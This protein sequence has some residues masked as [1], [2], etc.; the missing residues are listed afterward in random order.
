MKE[1]VARCCKFRALIIKATNDLPID[2]T[3][4]FQFVVA[5]FSVS[6][7]IIYTIVHQTCT[8]YNIAYIL[9]VCGMGGITSG[10]KFIVKYV[11]FVTQ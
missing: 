6:I 1:S 8:P 5:E 10:W 4:S 9:W 7:Y 11:F 2:W 3:L